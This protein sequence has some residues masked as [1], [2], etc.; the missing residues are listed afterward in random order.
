MIFAGLFLLF[1]LGSGAG[2]RNR[3][4]VSLITS[5]PGILFFDQREV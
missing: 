4:Q 3:R 2:L 5:P 1:V